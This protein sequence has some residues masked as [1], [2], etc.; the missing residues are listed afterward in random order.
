MGA[1]RLTLTVKRRRS[2]MLRLVA[3]F[4]VE[5]PGQCLAT[6]P[7]G[8]DISANCTI[9]TFDVA[10]Q[11][12]SDSSGRSKGAGE[13]HWTYV[14]DRAVV[15]VTRDETEVPPPVVPDEKGVRDYTVQAQY[16]SERIEEYGAAALEATNRVIRFFKFRLRTPFLQEF[17]AGHHA[18]RN[19]KWTDPS[20]NL[21]GKGMMAFVARGIPGL[22]G[23]L[24]VEKLRPESIGHLQ[25]AI[26]ERIEPTLPEQILSDAQTAIFEKNLRRAVIE[27][28]IACE[29]VVKRSFFSS[30]S[31]AGAAF[32]YLE[33]K[34]QVRVTVKDMIDR[35]AHEAF[36]KSFLE[37]HPS[38]YWHVDHLFRC[39]NKVAHR[40]ELSFRDDKGQNIAVEQELVSDWWRA[41]NTLV[42]WLRAQTKSTP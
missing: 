15:R 1:R 26:E 11:L 21:V 19:A 22:W 20:G 14:L 16:F 3:T 38:Q 34:S 10:L 31:P 6:W 32:D 35:V 5:L 17:P 23:Q 4:E 39:R 18:F 12:C 36:G 24:S 25:T 9:G 29:I 27:L 28:A 37:D 13:E 30:D 2:Q 42:G 8:E 41:V 33:D 7:E 40:G